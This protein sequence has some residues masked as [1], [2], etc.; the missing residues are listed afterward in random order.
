M[1][2]VYTFSL[3]T[4]IPLFLGAAPR[5]QGHPVL[6]LTPD[7]VEQMKAHSGEVPLFDNSVASLIAEA[8]A[9]IKAPLCLP[10]PKDGGGGYSH[11]MHKRN[12]YDMFACGMAWQLTP[13]K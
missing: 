2:K 6:L 11:E 10:E 12:Y 4:L 3:L 1:K 8:D 5:K 13:E 9:A 7:G